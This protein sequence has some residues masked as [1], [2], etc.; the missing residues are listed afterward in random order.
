MA[1]SYPSLASSVT[2][3][4][5]SNVLEVLL[6]AHRELADVLTHL[7]RERKPGRMPAT[8][9]KE[10][11]EEGRPFDRASA[12]SDPFGDGLLDGSYD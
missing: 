11:G 12:K 2:E 3:R 7:T 8:T 5:L 9:G 4:R 1:D 10:A 6:N